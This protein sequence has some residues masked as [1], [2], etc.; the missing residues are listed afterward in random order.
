MRGLCVGCVWIVGWVCGEI[1]GRRGFRFA[2]RL[3]ATKE[4]RS[5]KAD[6]KPWE[7]KCALICVTKGGEATTACEG[8]RED[9]WEDSREDKAVVAVRGFCRVDLCEDC[10]ADLCDNC[11]E[12]LCEDYEEPPDVGGVGRILQGG[13][14]R[15]GGGDALPRQHPRGRRRVALW[16]GCA[17]IAGRRGHRLVCGLQGGFVRGLQGGEGGGRARILQGGF[18]RGL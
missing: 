4:R 18:V 3:G 10:R 12:D 2:F 16:E 6:G 13:C 7:E 9:L 1:A 15:K 17:W 14:G 5:E 8:G 11:R